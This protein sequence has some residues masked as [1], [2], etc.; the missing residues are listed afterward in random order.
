VFNKAELRS[1]A[2]AG[3]RKLEAAL[4][5]HVVSTELLTYNLTNI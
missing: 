4:P 1:R 3:D 2:V 5:V